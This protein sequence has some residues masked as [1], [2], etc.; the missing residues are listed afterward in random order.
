[1][2]SANKFSKVQVLVLSLLSSVAIPSNAVAQPAVAGRFTIS[3]EALWGTIVLPPGDYTFAVEQDGALPVVMIY[4]AR[5]G[6]KGMVFPAYVTEMG[7]S[8]SGKVTLENINGEKVVT[9]LSVEKLGLVLHYAP[10]KANVEIA[11]KKAMPA[12]GSNSYAQAK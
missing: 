10:D 5:G 2:K 7:R 3:S 11:R 1:M 4:L 6:A 8:E 9:A 12:A